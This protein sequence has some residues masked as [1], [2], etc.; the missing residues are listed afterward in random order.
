MSYLSKSNINYA[1]S[2]IGNNF[3]EI[4]IIISEIEKLEKINLI[5]IRLDKIDSLIDEKLLNN[6]RQLTSK[7]LIATFRCELDGGRLKSFSKERRE[8]LIQAV[9]CGFDLVDIEYNRLRKTQINDFVDNVKSINKNCKIIISYHSFKQNLKY[10]VV[11]N[12]IK[13]MKRLC[14]PDLVKIA[15]RIDNRNNIKNFVR[16]MFD[17]KRMNNLS[18]GLIGLGK[19]S[20]LCRILATYF[21]QNLIFVSL[22]EGLESAKGQVSYE[23]YFEIINFFEI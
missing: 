14:N 7:K 11:K 5:E 13:E 8:Y 18:V 6:I 21:K 15:F 23:K 22:K 20:K 10:G 3:T 4:K 12:I 17:F 9:Q 2:V 16:M 1:V 19:Y